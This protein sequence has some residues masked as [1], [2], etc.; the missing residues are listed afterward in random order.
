[1]WLQ[2]EVKTQNRKSVTLYNRDV[3]QEDIQCVEKNKCFA[4]LLSAGSEWKPKQ[5]KLQSFC[6][7]TLEVKENSLLFVGQSV[8]FT[9]SH[10]ITSSHTVALACWP[11]LHYTT[12]QSAFKLFSSLIRWEGVLESEWR[13]MSM[14]NKMRK[15][16]WTDAF[17]CSWAIISVCSDGCFVAWH[18]CSLTSSH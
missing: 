3:C 14:L 11:G 16:K 10:N 15:G 2:T 18:R 1:M 13:W 7:H 4:C 8:L 17:T 6:F 5:L 9:G 12:S